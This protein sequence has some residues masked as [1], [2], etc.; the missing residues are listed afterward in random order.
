MKAN[1]AITMAKPGDEEKI[2]LDQAKLIIN[3]KILGIVLGLVLGLAIFIA[4]N[5]LVV[6]GGN[7]GEDGTPQVGYHLSLI[8]HF[9]YGYRVS[10]L[11]SIIGF[12]YGFALGTITGAVFAW[13]YNGLLKIRQSRSRDNVY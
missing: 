5:W 10:F 11:G 6:K 7:I 3:F 8:S 4:T 12:L 13:L 1:T 2:L 9:F